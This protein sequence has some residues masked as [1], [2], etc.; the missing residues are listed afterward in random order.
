MAG[1]ARRSGESHSGAPTRRGPLAPEVR[2]GARAGRHARVRRGC[3]SPAR[4]GTASRPLPGPVSGCA[5]APRGPLAVVL[6]RGQSG[7]RPRGRRGWRAVLAGGAVLSAHGCG[8]CRAPPGWPRLRRA[9]R[10][11]GGS[12]FQPVGWLSASSPRLGEAEPGEEGALRGAGWA[13]AQPGAATPHMPGTWRRRCRAIVWLAGVW[14]FTVAVFQFF[15]VYKFLILFQHGF[16][17]V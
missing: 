16:L 10:G 7:A 1:P 15:C 3:R 14:D 2:S 13:P 8:D 12:H 17:T 6:P 4:R 11:I 9:G 5:A